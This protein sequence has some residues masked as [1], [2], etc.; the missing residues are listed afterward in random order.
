MYTKKQEK[1]IDRWD[2]VA[3]SVFAFGVGVSL[4]FIFKGIIGF[5]LAAIFIIL[6]EWDNRQRKRKKTNSILILP[7]CSWYSIKK[8]LR[9]G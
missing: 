1:I 5:L 4:Y 8:K 9:G 6:I 2:D 7:L 3:S